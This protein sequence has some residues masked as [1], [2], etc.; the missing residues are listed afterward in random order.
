MFGK[1]LP[2]RFSSLRFCQRRRMCLMAQANRYLSPQRRRKLISK[3]N[4]RRWNKALSLRTKRRC[5]CPRKHRR[6]NRGVMDTGFCSG[7]TEDHHE[8]IHRRGIHYSTE[9]NAP[10]N[11]RGDQLRRRHNQRVIQCRQDGAEAAY[12]DTKQLRLRATSQDDQAPGVRF[13]TFASLSL[14]SINQVSIAASGFN[15]S[16]P[17]P[18]STSHAARSG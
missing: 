9:A 3:R 13:A 4:R 5:D 10:H 12:R 11:R 7:F 14:A 8:V 1:S 18:R 6:Q 16:D 15:E 2:D 17:I